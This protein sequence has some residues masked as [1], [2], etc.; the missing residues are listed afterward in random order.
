MALLFLVGDLLREHG[1]V[2]VRGDGG[3]DQA[4]Q[5]VRF[6]GFD[7]PLTGWAGAKP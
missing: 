4:L 5:L 7:L 2:D 1:A 3:E 6:E